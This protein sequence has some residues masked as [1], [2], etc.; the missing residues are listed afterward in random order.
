MFMVKPKYSPKKAK[1]QRSSDSPAQHSSM[2]N[3]C[4]PLRHS[5]K[6]R[7]KDTVGKTTDS[8]SRKT[9]L[10]CKIETT[11]TLEYMSRRTNAE[12]KSFVSVTVTRINK[13]AS[14]SIVR[15]IPLIAFQATNKPKQGYESTML[16]DRSAAARFK[17]LPIFSICDGRRSRKHSLL[18]LIVMA[19]ERWRL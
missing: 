5:G 4:F 16:G 17:L 8:T 19:T 10:R 11:K 2:F 12:S 9:K 18:H 1:K 13:R 15:S 14:E 6:M 7:L 3:I